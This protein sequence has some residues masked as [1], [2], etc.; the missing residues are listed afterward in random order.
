MRRVDLYGGGTVFV[1]GLALIFWIIPMTTFEGRYYGLSPAFFPTVLAIGLCICALIQIIKALISGR[2]DA[3]DPLPMNGVG[4]VRALGVLGLVFSGV[5]LIDL[6]DV[7]LGAPVLIVALAFLL[8][9]RRPVVL[10]GL[11]VVPVTIAWGVVTLLLRIPM[12]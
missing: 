6:T 11:A 8:G 10:A 1:F 9:E 5:V 2:A 7:R 4:L 3:A 12:P